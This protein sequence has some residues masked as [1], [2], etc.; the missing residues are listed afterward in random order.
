MAMQVSYSVY[1]KIQ[2]ESN[3]LPIKSRYP[4]NNKRFVQME[5]DRDNRRPY[6]GGSH[7]FTFINSS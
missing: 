3:I 6:D 5:S 2:E 4:E 7:T 1:A